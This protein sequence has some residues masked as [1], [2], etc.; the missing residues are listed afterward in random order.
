MCE[1]EKNFDVIYVARC[2]CVSVCDEAIKVKVTIA[3][4][5]RTHENRICAIIYQFLNAWFPSRARTY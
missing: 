3:Q 4:H 5:L 1:L 2:V